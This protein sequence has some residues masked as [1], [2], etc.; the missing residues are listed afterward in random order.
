MASDP[1]LKAAAA[2]LIKQKLQPFLF[3]LFVPPGSP[4]LAPKLYTIWNNNKQVIALFP[5][6]DGDSLL[7]DVTFESIAWANRFL[8][9]DVSGSLGLRSVATANLN[10]RCDSTD[11]GETGKPENFFGLY[12]QATL[13]EAD[14]PL[15]VAKN[16]IAY[17]LNPNA[18]SLKVA[19]LKYTADVTNPVLTQVAQTVE[20][21]L[22]ERGYGS[23]LRGG[24]AAARGTYIL[25]ADADDS[26]DLSSL[27]PFVEKLREGYDLVVGWRVN[28]Q[29]K[30]L[31]RRVPSQL[32]NWLIGVITGVSTSTVKTRLRL[33]KEHLRRWLERS[34]EGRRGR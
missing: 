2:A 5:N 10:C 26:Y 22:A 20:Q 3:K 16:A 23:T 14:Y 30:W 9:E 24:F 32:A 1:V 13:P 33:G 4:V 29:D 25:M 18:P 27:M 11:T 31:S 6:S 19:G 28:R 12:I 8:V 15:T 34:G 17:I 21:L 7:S